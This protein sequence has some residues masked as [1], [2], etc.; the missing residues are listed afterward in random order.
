MYR[1][2]LCCILLTILLSLQVHAIG[3]QVPKARPYGLPTYE[4]QEAGKLDSN[5]FVEWVQQEVKS[6]HR[7]VGL[8]EGQYEASAGYDDAHIL[9]K[10]LKGVTVWMD[11]VNM[12]MSKDDLNAFNILNCTDLHTY[13][14]TVWW[15][16]PGFSQATVSEVK[17]TGDGSTPGNGD[18]DITIHLDAG[19]DPK[20]LLDVST[21]Y[22]DG[23]YTDP[24]T[25]RLQAGPGWSTLSGQASP[26]P[27]R[28]MY[29]TFPAPNL[30]F[31][32]QI[33]H[34]ILARGKF[35]FC[36]HVADSTR[37]VINDFTLLNCA[38]FG[39]FSS[40]NR[41]TTFD[42]LSIKPADFAPPGGTE[43]PARSSSA[44][45]IHSAGDFIGPTFNHC[46][47]SALDD[48]CMA[49][50]GTLY[51]IT[52]DADSASSIMTSN[53]V[54]ISGE[55]VNFYADETFEYLGR[56]TIKSVSE[57]KPIIITFTTVLPKN[58]SSQLT[59]T[60]WVNTARL[61]SGFQVLNT[62][63]TGNRG[64]G[65]ITKA[66]NGLIQNNTFE[67]VSYGAITMGPEFSSWGEAGYVHNLALKDNVVRDCN[68]LNKAGSAVQLHGDGGP[69]A[70]NLPTGMNSNITIDGLVIDGVSSS[71]LLLEATNKLSIRNVE[72]RNAYQDDA[73]LWESNPG[74]LIT[75]NGV[76]FTQGSSLGCVSGGIGRGGVSFL[77]T[78]G[79]VIGLSP[80]AKKLVAC[81][82]DISTS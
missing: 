73:V 7:N 60:M 8:K 44:D 17:R 69:Q 47:F 52:G 14:P 59:S 64:R 56:A 50:H 66:S 67:G 28:P 43:L 77:K 74:A 45:G 5:T 40:G 10:D 19:Y 79:K 62:H 37:T 4:P 65:I 9:F 31:V 13:G 48:D 15:D 6:G 41:R 78:L 53:G 3:P 70:K 21:N 12:T 29:Y 30:Y 61:G 36:N 38:G 26:V 24:S 80:S 25:G 33:G 11:G 63:T 76:S 68:Y 71:N 82:D 54:G 81:G 1:N 39:W 16:L 35:I 34:K 18:Y 22:L 49:V 27:G 51:D 32:P 55:V 72:F 75:A 20:Y 23:A 58:V 57:D 42:S 46:L 2:T